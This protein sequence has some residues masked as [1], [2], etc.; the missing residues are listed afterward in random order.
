M[1][2]TKVITRQTGET[3]LPFS[4]TVSVTDVVM[5]QGHW[6]HMCAHGII[7]RRSISLVKN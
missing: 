6:V 7:T 4:I 5:N 3:F 1:H 2:A